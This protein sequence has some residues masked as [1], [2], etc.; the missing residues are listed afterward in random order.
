[1]DQPSLFV[2]ISQNNYKTPHHRIFSDDGERFRLYIHKLSASSLF[3][4]LLRKSAL[5]VSFSPCMENSDQTPQPSSH[6][7]N[8]PAVWHILR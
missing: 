3:G 4:F 7:Q 2:Y 6:P 8:T 1:N 5:E